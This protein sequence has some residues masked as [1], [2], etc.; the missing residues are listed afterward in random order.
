MLFPSNAGEQLMGMG[1][2]VT[3]TLMP[4]SSIPW[5][6]TSSGV[7]GTHV[8]FSYPPRERIGN[9]RTRM[10]S[11]SAISSSVRPGKTITMAL[12]R[13]AAY[14]RRRCMSPGVTPPNIMA[15]RAMISTK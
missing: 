3:L 5:R 12:A 7:A 4:L 15:T 2:A 14:A 9:P 6:T 10:P 11:T 13:S 8:A 1:I